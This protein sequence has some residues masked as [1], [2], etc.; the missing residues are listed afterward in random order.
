MIKFFTDVPPSKYILFPF[1]SLVRLDN[2]NKVGVVKARF[3]VLQNY[4]TETHDVYIFGK[5]VINLFH[6]V[7]T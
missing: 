1:P 4:F 3:T 6:R 5:I 2:S 7:L